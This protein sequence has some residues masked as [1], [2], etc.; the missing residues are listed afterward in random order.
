MNLPPRLHG[1]V[2]H[3]KKKIILQ[4]LVNIHSLTWK[5]CILFICFD[6]LIFL[7]FLNLKFLF[8][9]LLLLQ[10]V[11]LRNVNR[12]TINVLSKNKSQIFDR[13]RFFER[14]KFIL[15]RMVLG[16]LDE[17][18][19][20]FVL[21]DFQTFPIFCFLNKRIFKY[22]IFDRISVASVSYT[23][24]QKSKRKIKFFFCQTFV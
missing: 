10:C 8:L 12:L 20:C 9:N 1:L 6:F 22:T 13:F 7:L 3:S 23:F 11:F 2:F 18:F 4:I 21:L 24:Q 14:G 19:S 17:S 5:P 15:L 16:H